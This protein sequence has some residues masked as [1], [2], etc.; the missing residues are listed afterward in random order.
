[1]YL[2]A[3]HWK[4]DL[5]KA[6]HILACISLTAV[7]LIMPFS[8]SQIRA[9]SNVD[10]FTIDN[11]FS[12]G[13]PKVAGQPF[14]VTIRAMDAA[15]NI[16]STFNDPVFLLDSNGSDYIFPRQTSA[17][18]N[19]IWTGNVA[20]TKAT[21]SDML[22]A[23]NGAL[24]TSS[25]TFTVLADTRQINLALVAGNDQ[26]AVVGATLP[27][28]LTVRAIDLYGNP[29]SNVGINFLIAAYPPNAAGQTLSSISGNSDIN[30]QISTNLKL[31]TKVGTYTI[32]G[33]T[34]AAN[35]QQLNI[36]AN[37]TAAN[38]AVLQINPVITVVPKGTSQQFFLIG[39]DAFQN[40]IVLQTAN[41]NVVSGGGT[42]DSNGVFTAGA[43]SGS[44]VSTVRAQIGQIGVAATVTVINE[45]SGNSEGDKPT[46]TSYGDGSTKIGA[47]ST[48]TPIP[49]A[50]PTLP[51]TPP[52]ADG[53]GSGTGVKDTRL[54]AGVLDRVYIVPNFV[55]I[56]SQARQL[57]V[58]QAYDRYNN[59]I[60]GITY[61][62][63][64]DGPIGDLSYATANSTEL[65]AASPGN[66]TMTVTA[67]QGTI[68]V[69]GTAKVAITAKTGGV[70]SFDT[71]TS[72]QKND[73]PFV[74]TITAK[75]FDN[76]L[77]AG[78]TGNVS[79]TDTT[80]SITPGSASH[81]SSGIWRGQV[82]I[83][84]ANDDVTITAIGQGMTG[85]SNSFKVVGAEKTALS[86]LRSL[87][88]ALSSS[89][90]TLSGHGPTQT[91]S[92]NQG[93]FLRNLGA[94][95]AAGLGLLGATLGVGLLSS[96]GLEA[97]GRN[98]MAKGKIQVNM[99]LAWL[100]SL[101]LGSIAI[102]SAIIIL[103]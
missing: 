42:I 29:I 57:V 53:A 10:H 86:T 31:G 19:G 7:F 38:I 79:L 93:Q 66:G 74:V 60:S 27:T 68:S 26:S 18:T 28:S 97:I 95:A 51:P 41:W 67:Q 100:V 75:D 12:F 15:G 85:I 35:S 96:K 8:N 21:A 14:Q 5:R 103:G 13:S 34:T 11:G 32:T 6:C 33:R 91:S 99:Y 62:W 36:Y 83:P 2:L 37:A 89:L 39:Y 44:F 84:F 73:Q 22:T 47:V 71:I 17:F 90:S 64:K 49:T 30:G 52:P 20:L 61:A 3:L 55:T 87:G 80:G 4:S 81:F 50:L 78:F 88:S 46:N 102:A 25:T 98:P 63:S 101:I 59:A 92:A 70:L 54:N 94:G 16:A 72:P 65:H 43:K 9:A 48:P 69:S 23:Y 82:K 40:P 45:T 58:A 76:N 77:L 1:M 56:T 24:S